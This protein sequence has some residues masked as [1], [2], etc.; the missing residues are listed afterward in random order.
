MPDE[1]EKTELIVRLPGVDGLPRREVVELPVL[2]RQKFGEHDYLARV[3]R[4]GKQNLNH[5]TFL[6]FRDWLN[7]R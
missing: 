7:S 6:W 1:N 2:L 5:F 3:H 4:T